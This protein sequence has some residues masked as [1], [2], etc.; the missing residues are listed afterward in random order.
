MVTKFLIIRKIRLIIFKNIKINIK[1][2]P[3]GRN[4]LCINLFKNH[5]IWTVI[6]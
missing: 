2:L 1:K 6:Y 5:T 3:Y 4:V